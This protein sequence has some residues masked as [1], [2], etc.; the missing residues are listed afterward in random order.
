MKYDFTTSP[1]RFNRGSV[2]YEVMK[3]LKPDVPEDVIPLSVA[4]MEFVLPDFL[5]EGI[6]EALEDMV[7]G[8]SK[9]TKTY[10]KTVRD[11]YERHFGY[12]PVP[13]KMLLTPGVVAALFLAVD[14]FTEPGDGVILMT[15]VYG[16]FYNA[17]LLQD[18][19]VLDCPIIETED[20]YKPDL[21]LFRELAQREDAKMLLFCHPHNPLGKIW[22]DEELAAILEIVEENDLFWVSDEIHS[23][24]AFEPIT[25][26][27]KAAK[28]YD[29]KV[30]MSSASK[31]FNLAGISHAH[32]F[33]STEEQKEAMAE[34]MMRKLGIKATNAFGLIA[35]EIA[36]RE[37]DEWLKELLQVLSS[38][39]DLVDEFVSNHPL[40]AWKRPQ[41]T[42]LAWIDFSGLGVSDDDFYD[43]CQEHD[44]FFTRGTF[45]GEGGKGHLRMNIA[46]PQ[47]ELR[48]ALD[49]LD[50]VL[51]SFRR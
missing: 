4:D 35:T 45:F 39:F 22:S 12:R 28:D 38:N 16:P 26:V 32:C 49:R 31:T 1:D 51:E 40:L 37:G 2:K 41:A 17:V 10:C 30:V 27:M 8:Y 6:Q 23:D 44:L 9:P 42:Y 14:A 21:K 29:K 46:L 33:T 15:P 19:K 36:C 25:S 48:K 50:Q 3:E 13:E 7:I 11:F 18:R 24:I 34:G 43:S 20:G 47:R 5:K